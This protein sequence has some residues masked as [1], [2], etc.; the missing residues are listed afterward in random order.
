MVPRGWDA[1]PTLLIGPS[2][3][4]S[5]NAWSREHF[6][7]GQPLYLH[8]WQNYFHIVQ[9][10]DSI[11]SACHQMK[12]LSFIST[13]WYTQLMLPGSYR[14]GHII[15]VGQTCN[16]VLLVNPLLCVVV[17][18]P[19]FPRYVLLPVA[20]MKLCPRIGTAATGPKREYFQMSPI[21]PTAWVN[22]T[23]DTPLAIRQC[24]H[25]QRNHDEVFQDHSRPSWNFVLLRT[26]QTTTISQIGK[27]NNS[28]RRRTHCQIWV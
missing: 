23:H 13:Y 19:M 6:H 8:T 14:R 7:K 27:I 2:P 10:T 1:G 12:V 9:V 15:N 26:R 17:I 16:I 4:P 18:C 21:V 20:P 11:V 24:T 25:G 28:S 3:R 5:W 22:L